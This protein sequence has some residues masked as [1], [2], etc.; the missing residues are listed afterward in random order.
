MSLGLNWE[1]TL[2]R[3]RQGMLSSVDWN[4]REGYVIDCASVLAHRLGRKEEAKNLLVEAGT[5]RPSYR[6]AVELSLLLLE[7]KEYS[8]AYDWSLE[9]LALADDR[10]IQASRLRTAY[11]GMDYLNEN[12]EA[13][14]YLRDYVDAGGADVEAL[15]RLRRLTP[16][17][18]LEDKIRVLSHLIQVLD[19]PD[20]RLRCRIDLIF[21]CEVSKP[22]W[23][24]GLETFIHS[25]LDEC[26]ESRVILSAYRIAKRLDEM[27]IFEEI[28]KKRGIDFV[29]HSEAITVENGEMGKDV[30]SREEGL[31]LALING[32]FQDDL[33]AWINESA[34]V[35]GARIVPIL[36][37]LADV[38]E[39]EGRDYRHVRERALEIA[40]SDLD[41]ECFPSSAYQLLG[42]AFCSASASGG[43]RIRA[44]QLGH[45]FPSLRY[46]SFSL[47]GFEALKLNQSAKAQACFLEAGKI[48][49]L[50]RAQARALRLLLW[51]KQDYEGV[52]RDLESELE[53][54]PLG[55][56]RELQL[57]LALLDEFL[58]QFER[59]EFQYRK[60]LETARGWLPAAYGLGT[61]LDRQG[62]WREL[63]SFVHDE[64]RQSSL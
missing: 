15:R 32:H 52:R 28:L 7:E 43:V 1:A 11:I 62:R 4:R 36:E 39:K 18:D 3:L 10:Q 21:L 34:S 19:E 50:G 30:R 29:H 48:N 31:L 53:L 6:L 61:L 24:L 59:A 26:T 14:A 5:E 46:H 64:L 51:H 45:R 17:V 37:N 40:L 47:A 63:A 55:S 27:S 8:G 12:V 58:G 60:I 38:L 22:D 44:E 41:V 54:V 20:E 56:R 42:D 13:K 9:A 16:D 25:E 49:A 57:E 35:F 33:E 2:E 23:Q